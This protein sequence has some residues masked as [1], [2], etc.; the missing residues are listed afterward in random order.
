ML[1]RGTRRAKPRGGRWSFISEEPHVEPS[2]GLEFEGNCG[3]PSFPLRLLLL[4]L[5]WRAHDLSVR[6]FVCSV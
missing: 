3:F 6:C 5:V 4:S 1:Q 2:I